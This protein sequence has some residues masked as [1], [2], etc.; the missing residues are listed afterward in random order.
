LNHRLAA[1]GLLA[2]ALALAVGTGAFTSGDELTGV[3]SSGS[4]YFSPHD[5]PNGDAYAT[6]RTAR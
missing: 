5:G 2:I 1:V 3:D 4:V 6:V